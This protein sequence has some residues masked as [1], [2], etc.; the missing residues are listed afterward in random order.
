MPLEKAV[1]QRLCMGKVLTGGG[2]K[3]IIKNSLREGFAA[4]AGP[5]LFGVRRLAFHRGG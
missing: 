4:G 5:S 3:S 2:G 1:W